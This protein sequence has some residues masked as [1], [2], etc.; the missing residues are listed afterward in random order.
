[1]SGYV[2]YESDCDA[3]FGKFAAGTKDEVSGNTQACRVKFLELAQSDAATHCPH[4]SPNG[5]RVCVPV[6]D[7]SFKSA[8]GSFEV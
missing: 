7:G 5:G 3:Q 1:M 2:A 6:A 8:D 4:A